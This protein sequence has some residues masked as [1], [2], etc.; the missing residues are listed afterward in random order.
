MSQTTARRMRGL[1]LVELCVTTTIA[2]VLAASAA[3][4]FSDLIE[5]QRM[6]AVLHELTSALALA[7][8]EA[9]ASGRRTAVAP[10]TAGQWTSGW[11]VFADVND[12]GVLDPGETV[13]QEHPAS[14]PGIDIATHFGSTRNIVLSY[15]DHGFARRPGANALLMGRMVISDGNTHRTVCFGA[16]RVRVIE[17]TTCP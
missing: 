3:P 17:G 2:A 13:L 8:S 15:A 5:R 10:R 16:T 4:S 1:T 9:V 12:N 14:P 6:Q 11:R 7:R